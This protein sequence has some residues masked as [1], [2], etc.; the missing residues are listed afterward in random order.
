MDSIANFINKLKIASKARK[1]SVL[2][3]SSRLI[4]SIAETLERKGYIA[5]FA[6]KGKKGRYVEVMLAYDGTFARL[7]GVKRISRLSKRVYKGAKDLRPVRN[8]Y[9]SAILSTPKGIL[10]DTEARA[11]KV[12]GEVLF[13]VW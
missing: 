3:P 10:L 1:E 9:G 11:Q 4:L 2:F 6:K 12:G 13:E 5:S 8:G 7:S